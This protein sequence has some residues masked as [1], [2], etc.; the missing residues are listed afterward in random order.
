MKHPI[1]LKKSI[2]K[3][4]LSSAFFEM[5]RRDEMYDQPQPSRPN[6]IFWVIGILI[7]LFV[8]QKT[9]CGVFRTE[10]KMEWLDK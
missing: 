9:G 3:P 5:E 7:L 4:A 10:E 6:W 2:L 1:F 8:M